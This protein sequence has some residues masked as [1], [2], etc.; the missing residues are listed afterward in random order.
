[1]AELHTVKKL[2]EETEIRA[3][4]EK[5]LFEEKTANFE[6]RMDQIGQRL[7]ELLKH[8]QVSPLV[9]FSSVETCLSHGVSL[10][11]LME[12]FLPRLAAPCVLVLINMPGFEPGP[13]G[14]D[15]NPGLRHGNLIQMH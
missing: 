13:S 5:A 3:K 9:I 1:M 2:N 6:K 11:M 14:R 7:D 10:D 12:I 15:S 4:A 8:Y